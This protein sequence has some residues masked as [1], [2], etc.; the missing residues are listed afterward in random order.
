M[1]GAVWGLTVVC[2]VLLAGGAAVAVYAA[3]SA[4]G[5]GVR[6][7]LAATFLACVGAPLLA[8]LYAP[9]GYR[10]SGV[11]LVID[12]PLGA[13]EVPLASIH[14][15]TRAARV[16]HGLRIWGSGG[17]FGIYGRFSNRELGRFRVY[18]RHLGEAVVLSTSSGT[19]VLLPDD[20]QA[21][22]RALLERS[23]PEGEI[24]A[25]S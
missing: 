1:D 2:L 10:L 8:W 13:I 16:P 15:F 11:A 19:L 6:L 5:G 23:I 18:G 4:S 7:L 3:L 22:T 9:T 20:V 14:T 12:R 25:T 21:F 17:L 24:H